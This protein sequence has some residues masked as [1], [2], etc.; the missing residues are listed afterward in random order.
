VILGART[1]DQLVDNLGSSD[2]DLTADEV[3]RLSEA[4]APRIDDY[5][6]GSGGVAHRRRNIEGL[7]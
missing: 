6:N 3:T 5:P 4:S 7:R 1:V 2:I